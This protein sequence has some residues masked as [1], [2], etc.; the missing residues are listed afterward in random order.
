FAGTGIF[1]AVGKGLASVAGF[2]AF[3]PVLTV[4][5]VIS[6]AAAIVAIR[7]R[8]LPE[9]ID[10]WVWVATGLAAW[11]AGLRFFG[12]YWLQVVPPVVLL[13]VPVVAR[14]TGRARTAAFVGVVVPAAVAWIL[15]FVPG[16]FHDR[17]DPSTLAN[18]V[19]A[20]TTDSDRVFVW[21]SYPEVL[22]AAE[23][24]PTGGLV[25]TDFVVGRSGG[26]NDPAE[27]LPSAVP[28]A[29]EIMLD[30]LAAHPPALILDT[31]TS[32]RL[33][34]ENFPMSLIPELDRFVR[35]GYDLVTTVDGVDI[36]RRR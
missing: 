18:Y 31:S 21:G 3:H 23:R 19:S 33:G 28:G 10:L 13:A 20:H 36:W 16:S 2:V 7:S 22:V 12:H 32:S 8:H 14:W 34:Y 35:D 30:S 17:P 4:A 11:A 25:H 1:S 24:L 5:I 15:L 27:T 29:R 9:D 26:R 6:A